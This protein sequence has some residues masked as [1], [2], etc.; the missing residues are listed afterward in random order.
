MDT[1]QSPS[2]VTPLAGARLPADRGLTGLGLLMQLVGSVMLGLMAMV[3]LAPIFAGAAPGAW[4]IFLL[5][6]T[7]AIRAAFHRAAGGALL[8]AGIDGAL[9]ALRRYVVVAFLATAAW[10][11]VLLESGAG[12]SLALPVVGA[13]AAWPVTLLILASRPSFRA[14]VE[15]SPRTAEDM[16][17][18]GTAV[19]MVILGALGAL[20]SLA[21][22]IALFKAKAWSGSFGP[23]GILLLGVFAMLAVRSIMHVNAGLKGTRGLDAD[24]ATDAAARYYSFGFVSSV[25]AGG[26]LLIQMMM[27]V[28]HPMGLL[29]IGLVVFFLL[30]W[31]LAL[32]RFYTERNFSILLAGDDAPRYHR[33][34]DAGMTALGWLL[35]MLA[36]YQIGYLVPT[37]LVGSP[38]LAAGQFADF[39]PATLGVAPFR[40]MWWQVGLAGLGLWAAIELIQMSD[41]YKVAATVYGVVAAAV[42]VY[43]YWP[44]LRAFQLG[45]GGPNLLGS[46]LPLSVALMMLVIPV[47]AVVLANR[48]LTPEA[49]ARIG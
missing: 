2:N 10:A 34:P 20:F 18:E 15:G 8:Y 30:I 37:V 24:G 6:A 5:G 4:P 16:G 47:T 21:A 49:T 41:R 13:L 1:A 38:G 25:I 43:L 42:T 44:M 45:G 7:G 32:R 40:S 33:A 26:A 22:L 46:L 3:A 12:A 35:L 36:T 9:P 29:M 11:A 19:L 31:P 14:L 27:S 28:L 23:A 17:F 39:N 48:K